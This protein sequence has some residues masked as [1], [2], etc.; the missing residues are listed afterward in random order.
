MADSFRTIT[1]EELKEKLDEHVE[2]TLIEVLPKV[3]YE[4]AHLPEAINIPLDDLRLM[5]PRLI[6]SEWSEI[7]VYCASPT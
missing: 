3:A 5:V 2:M 1:R 7:V 6:P 4:H